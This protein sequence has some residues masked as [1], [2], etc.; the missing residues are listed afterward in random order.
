M[1]WRLGSKD[2][3]NFATELVRE[4][5]K[6]CPPEA[7]AQGAQRTATFARA[8]DDLWIRVA[9][10]QRAKRLGVY[11][12]AKFGTAFKFQLKDLGYDEELVDELLRTLLI[13]MSGK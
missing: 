10:F 13:R 6:R 9:E 1:F 3:E 8:V 4:F 12:K 5:S 11:G 2:T 7:L